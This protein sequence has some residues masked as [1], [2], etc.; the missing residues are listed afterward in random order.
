ML[1]N[2][3]DNLNKWVI[4]VLLLLVAV[5]LVFMGLGDYQT[6]SESYAF[7]IGDKTVSSSRLEQEIF[8][9][10]QAL[11]RNNNNQIPPV[12]TDEFIRD[13]TIDYMIRTMLLDDKARSL[14]LVFHNNSI[15][16][17]IMNTSAFRNENGFDKDLY[18]SQLYKINMS[19]ESYEG[20]IYQS[21]IT[22]QLKKAITE[23][24][25]ITKSEE[26]LLT[27]YRFHTRDVSYKILS[28]NDIKKNIIISESDIS[29]YY[30]NNLSDFMTTTSATFNYIDISKNDLIKDQIVSDKKIRETYQEKRDNGFYSEPIKYSI[31]HILVPLG[32]NM[33]ST[34]TNIKSDLKAGIAL[35]EII[36]NYEVDEDTKNTDGFL[37]TFELEDLPEYFRKPIIDLPDSVFSNPIIS[38]NG[39]HFI[40][41]KNRTK[42]KIIE[43][44]DV[45]AEILND[46]KTE[47]GTRLYFDLIDQ[48]GELSFSKS[49]TLDEI[50]N[51]S[52][53][54]LILSKEI[55]ENEGYGI[56]NYDNVRNILFSKEII[57]DDKV[58]DLIYINDN[59]FI[60][61]EK[62]KSNLP[63]QMSLMESDE[64]IKTLLL[65]LQTRDK[66]QSIADDITVDLNSNTIN[67][68]DSFNNFLGT[69]DNENLDSNLVKIF[70]EASP[71]LG[72]QQYPIDDGKVIFRINQV[73]YKN[74][75]TGDE[76]NTFLNFVNNT[77]SETEFYNL[78][79]NLRSNSEI[80]IKK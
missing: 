68:D 46:L 7:K 31:E 45:R 42:E 34:V 24:S 35:T 29:Q 70:F 80:I 14:N 11:L 75:V 63:T 52:G 15:V 57:Y 27:K 69:I 50:A 10:K 9:Y 13:I 20:Y 79:S 40:R 38:N 1:R 25:F 6:S 28:K 67:E 41:I 51:K 53:Q 44:E 32:D 5:P 54:K 16:D 2:I 23:T 17:K 58:S 76:L 56:F 18:L 72:Y 71:L 30:N 19:P 77:R 55:S 8:Q 36:A 37:G 4:G 64:I 49:F 66:L 3:R 60:V 61:A 74:D 43:F 26:N 22:Q 21:G 48:I 47:K 33:N 73:E 59:R 39:T 12:Y 62:N 65:E 78:Y